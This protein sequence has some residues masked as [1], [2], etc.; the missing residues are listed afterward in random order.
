MKCKLARQLGLD[1]FVASRFD[2]NLPDK[3]FV[4]ENIYTIQAIIKKMLFKKIVE[5]NFIFYPTV[6]D[7]NNKRWMRIE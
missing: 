1:W 7:P 6:Y 2:K 4:L 3:E 5:C